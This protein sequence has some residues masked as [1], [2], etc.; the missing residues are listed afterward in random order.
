M[1]AAIDV[2]HSRERFVTPRSSGR[3]TRTGSRRARRSAPRAPRARQISLPALPG[4][5][6]ATQRRVP[7][8]R[9]RSRN[10]RAC[11]SRRVD[12]RHSGIIYPM[13]RRWP[14]VPPEAPR[15]AVQ[16]RGARPWFV[17]YD[18]FDERRTC[19]RRW[20]RTA[21]NGVMAIGPPP[22]PRRGCRSHQGSVE[23]GLAPP[24]PDLRRWARRHAVSTLIVHPAT[25]LAYA[26]FVLE[27]LAQVLGP[28]AIQYSTDG[29]PPSYGGGRVLCVLSRR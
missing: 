18:R 6:L 25:D 4:D 13:D 9:P 23:T 7:G 27:G 1:R 19:K 5:R 20:V 2:A 10:R 15:S 22:H 24:G 21:D 12:H 3:A 26:S 8:S 16:D 17:V 14:A 11:W 29:F 28:G